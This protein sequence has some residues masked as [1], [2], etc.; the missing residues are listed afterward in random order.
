MRPF[1]VDVDPAVVSRIM[2]KVR[3]FEWPV[4]PGTGDW[5]LGTDSAFLRK[6]QTHWLERFDWSA[7]QTELNRFP[8]FKAGIDGIDVHFLFKKGSGPSPMPLLLVHG[9]P[10]STLEFHGIIDSLADPS[11]ADELASFD[12]IAASLPGYGFSGKPVPPIGPRRTAALFNK[13]MAQVL[14]YDRYFSQGGDWG[15]VVCSWLAF[16]HPAHNVAIHL[17]LIGL[18]PGGEGHAPKPLPPRTD[19]EAEWTRDTAARMAMEGGYSAVQMTRPQTLG[20]GLNDSPMGVAAWIIEKFHAWSD[21]DGRQLDELFGLDLLLT[22]IMIYLVTNSF[23]TSTWMYRGA[24]EEGTFIPHGQRVDVPVALAN[25][26]FDIIRNP[27]RSY[28][29]QAY[30]IERW[31][32]FDRGGHFAALEAPE[33]MVTD[34]R[35]FFADL[36]NLL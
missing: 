14:G 4:D 10:G 1:I 35:G 9:W 23:N 36:R 22:N 15:C 3:A 33:Q 8:Q 16:D 19:E 7:A 27:P 13:L 6:L 29:E 21:R 17:N 2:A 31:T 24:L 20:Y 30:R 12:V 28:V 32:D 34:I 11:G 18:L 25:F 5:S 26:P